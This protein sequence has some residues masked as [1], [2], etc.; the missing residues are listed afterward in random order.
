MTITVEKEMTEFE[1]LFLKSYDYDFKVAGVVKGTVLK[2]DKNEILVDIGSKS[3]AILPLRELSNVHFENPTDIINVGDEKDFYI[4]KEE[5]EDGTITLSL[6]RVTFA[7]SWR[8]LDECR[9]NNDTILVKISNLVK[10]GVVVEALDL[11][12]FIPSSQL[13][14]GTPYDGLIGQEIPVKILEADPKKNKLILSQRQALA[15]ER[16][17]VVGDVIAELQVDQIVKGEIVRIADFGAFIDINGVDGLLPISEISWQRIK[18]PSDVLTLGEQIEVKVLKI[19]E[20]L[21]RISLSLKRMGENPW[22]KIEGQFKE[23]EIISGTVNKITSFG[24]FVNIFEGVEA[25]LP[26]AE[27]SEQEINPFNFLRVGEKV[28]VIIKKFTPQEH[29]ISLSIKDLKKSEKPEKQQKEEKA[30]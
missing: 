7:K 27:M 16:E 4:L 8:E 6:K 20:E 28:Q 25:L 12:G 23:G 3:E 15:E 24:A 13:R 14:T 26:V 5:N 22:V 21:N 19:D 17:K 18:H 9:K 1:K 10:G 29:R 30:E 11:R 2:V